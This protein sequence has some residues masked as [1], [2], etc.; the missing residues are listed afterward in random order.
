MTLDEF[1][2]AL[3]SLNL[4]WEVGP[5]N[6]N[7]LGDWHPIR[8]PDDLCPLQ[9][10]FNRNFSTALKAAKDKGLNTEDILFSA[11]FTDYRSKYKTRKKLK[12]ACR[13]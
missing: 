13:L 8:T 2:S 12:K 3:K 1:L 7:A 5:Y 10:V 11:D 6:D 4:K 9:A